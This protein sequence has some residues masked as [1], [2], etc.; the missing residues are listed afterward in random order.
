M[1]EAGRVVLLVPGE[2]NP[3]TGLIGA[4]MRYELGDRLLH[5]IDAGGFCAVVRNGVDG[6]WLLCLVVAEMKRSGSGR[7]LFPPMR[8]GIPAFGM[9]LEPV[10]QF[11][12][13]RVAGRDHRGDRFPPAL[14]DAKVGY[15]RPQAR[16]PSSA[17]YRPI[18][19][20]RHG[21]SRSRARADRASRSSCGR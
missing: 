2:V 21:T 14:R 6:H 20:C 15:R 11:A 7:A 19:D 12:P 4:D 5:L 1:H 17:W 3:G 13:G 9:G 10:H 16:F 18:P 8:P